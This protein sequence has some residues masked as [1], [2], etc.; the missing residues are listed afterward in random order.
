[1]NPHF[2]DHDERADYEDLEAATRQQNRLRR[3]KRSPEKQYLSLARV[4]AVNGSLVLVVGVVTLFGCVEE[5]KNG[6]KSNRFLHLFLAGVGCIVCGLVILKYTFQMWNWRSIWDIRILSLMACLFGLVPCVGYLFFA[7]FGVWGLVISTQLSIRK[8]FRKPIPEY[9]NLSPEITNEQWIFSP[10]VQQE[11]NTLQSK[12]V[13]EFNNRYLSSFMLICLASIIL[14]AFVVP[15]STILIREPRVW[16]AIVPVPAFFM[17]TYLNSV[18]ALYW[19]RQRRF[20][21]LVWVIIAGNL[22][23]GLVP[24]FGGINYI[25]SVWLIV[26]M[27]C[28][29]VRYTYGNRR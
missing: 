13:E 11:Q 17:V 28:P 3:P 10:S 15:I 2:S 24:F 23:L 16:G 19:I 7:S 12:M 25:F 22:L 14:L 6:I 27:N 1:M 8:K 20:I 18:L 21:Y 5:T 4:F 26:L 29:E 9:L